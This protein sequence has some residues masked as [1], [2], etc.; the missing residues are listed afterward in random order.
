MTPPCTHGAAADPKMCPDC[1]RAQLGPDAADPDIRA[2]WTTLRRG[3]ADM[4][5]PYVQDH[6]VDDLAKRAVA[7]LLA[8]PGW[9]P[10]LRMAPAVIRDARVARAMAAEDEP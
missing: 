2:A 1:R 6:L 10:P 8:G 3:L 7:E 9:K 5:R 4:L